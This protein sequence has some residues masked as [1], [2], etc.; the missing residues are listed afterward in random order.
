MNLKTS[1]IYIQAAIAAL[2]YNLLHIL[3]WE[4]PIAIRHGWNVNVIGDGVVI[5]LSVL[6]IILIAF[7]KKVG[8]ILGF[9]PA[10]WAIFLQWFLVYGMFVYKEPNGVWWYPMFPIFQ[11]IMIVFFSVLA[12]RDIDSQAEPKLETGDGLKSPSIYLYS[13][14]A[15]LLVQT[16]QK[17][18]R[19]LV[20]GFREH[21][22]LEGLI[23]SPILTIIALGAAVLLIKRSKSGLGLAI[24]SGL[25]L[26][27][28]PIVY[29]IILG[30]PCIGGIW[31]YPIFTAIQGIFII[32]FSALVMLKERDIRKLLRH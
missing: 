1:S 8:L 6:S 29:H 12:Y 23:P 13:V 4:L 20:V 10:F 28:Q 3:S 15:F 21:G 24:F 17:F 14:A 25:I 26:V 16:G 27:A 2:T 22:G 11:G 30:K 19:E 9:I 7:R 32:Y 18:V 5:A 31:W